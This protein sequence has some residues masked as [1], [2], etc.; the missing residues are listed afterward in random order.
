M[1]SLLTQ[2]T[3]SG[4]LI[5]A[6]RPI[7]DSLPWH[8]SQRYW[9]RAGLEVFTSGEVPYV[10]TNDGE[11]SRKALELYLAS[12]R[13]AD[14]RGCRE[15]NSYVLELG[16]GTGL[17]AKLFLDQLKA[18]SIDEQTSDYERTTYLVV[19][20]SPGLL[21][22]T[23]TSGVFSEHE[24]RVVRLNLPSHGLCEALASAL[25]Q[26][27]GKVRAVHANYVLDSLPFTILSLSAQGLFELRIQTYLN[28]D[29]VRP[30]LNPT[31][32]S[33]LDALDAWLVECSDAETS[34]GQRAFTFSGEYV[35]VER[36]GLPYAQLIPAHEPTQRHQQLVHSFG[37]VACLKEVSQLLRRDG[38]F[39]AMDYGYQGMHDE[40]LEFQC[41]SE[42]VAAGV[43][44]AQLAAFAQSEPGLSVV[45]PKTDPASLQARLF[46]RD[47]VSSVVVQRFQELYDKDAWDKTEAP[48]QEALSLV[49]RGLY[50]AARWRFDGALRLQP[51]NWN[52][53]E[54]IVSFLNYTLKEHVSALE[55]AK[56]ALKLN[57]LSPRI[58]NLLGDCYYELGT[59][60]SAES[61]YRQAIRINPVDVRARTNL[62]YVFLKKQDCAGALRM[63]GEAL[64]LD[65]TGAFREELLQKQA[66]ALQ[67]TSANQLRNAFSSIQQLSGHHALP[68][69]EHLAP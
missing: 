27:L 60:D 24:E 10:I 1:T 51:F 66:E 44:F 21:D 42:S 16:V 6:L 57:H 36:S 32:L 14:A 29:F 40:P 5:H 53:M 59:L 61:A 25:P 37:A 56:R 15:Q 69:R 28:E 52:L 55:V 49:Q 68:G 45:A 62:V 31:A 19:D 34:S 18:R 48:Y 46:A 7:W 8:R 4:I 2:R 58:W 38:Y 22:D 23:R 9:A 35:S 11:Q 41:F 47:Q 54:A 64:A 17:F 26:A 13:E 43:N 65:R 12:L 63:V 67:V 50:E 39:V 30:G 33:D 20:N 3:T